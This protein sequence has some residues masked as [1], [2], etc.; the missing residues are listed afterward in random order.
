MHIYRA[1]IMPSVKVIIIL[2]PIIADFWHFPLQDCFSVDTARASVLGRFLHFGDHR[3]HMWH[4]R[5]TENK[6][7][8]CCYKQHIK[9]IWPKEQEEW[10]YAACW[11]DSKQKERLG[12]KPGQFHLSLPS[13]TL[14]KA[15]MWILVLAFRLNNYTN[16]ALSPCAAFMFVLFA[17]SCLLI[18]PILT[19]V[20]ESKTWNLLL[21][22]GCILVLSVY[23]VWVFPSSMSVLLCCLQLSHF[24][25][26]GHWS[27][28]LLSF[29]ILL[30]FVWFTCSL[31]LAFDVESHLTV[32]FGKQPLLSKWAAW[33]CCSLEFDQ[34]IAILELRFP[35]LLSDD[36]GNS[37]TGWSSSV[38]QPNIT[39]Q[40][41]WCN[42]CSFES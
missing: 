8:I 15:V 30:Y 6:L 5:V 11:N 10:N 26:V 18:A 37:S 3:D 25:L 28:L 35:T 40:I 31:A 22:C 24:W 17:L 21:F 13:R 29:A 38:Y 20:C 19:V 34:C 27:C 4:R 9:I 33:N 41:K 16:S 7:C 12:Y 42:L 36:N 39:H 23:I 2:G 32:Y 1:L 14:F